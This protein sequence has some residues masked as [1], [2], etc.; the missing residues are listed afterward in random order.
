MSVMGCCPVLP[1]VLELQF[2]HH[3]IHSVGMAGTE[4][5][6]PGFS[7]A[8]GT[9]LGAPGAVSEPQLHRVLQH[10][11]GG[12]GGVRRRAGGPH[13]W[14]ALLSPWKGVTC[15]PQGTDDSELAGHRVKA[16]SL[17]RAGAAP[18]APLPALPA[19][20][21]SSVSPFTPLSFSDCS[22]SSFA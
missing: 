12:Q 11:A 22:S 20:G 10:P 3:V 4:G 2:S 6:S 18:G 8:P 17:R 9:P 7:G 5:V 15:A 19:E 1:V 13:F 14:V 21:G 16:V